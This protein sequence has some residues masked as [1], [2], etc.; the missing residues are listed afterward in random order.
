M[1][2]ETGSYAGRW[3]ERGQYTYTNLHTAQGISQ[4]PHSIHKVPGANLQ[5]LKVYVAQIKV[6]LILS[7][8]PNLSVAMSKYSKNHKVAERKKLR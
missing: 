6:V 7:Q 2:Y 4:Y 8:L 3:G 1:W 5:F